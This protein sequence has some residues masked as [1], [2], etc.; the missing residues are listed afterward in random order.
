MPLQ[1][2]F[3]VSTLTYNIV[4][5]LKF[6]S[7]ELKVIGNKKPNQNKENSTSDVNTLGLGHNGVTNLM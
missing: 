7:M 3:Q 4:I 2:Q 1:L 5:L 6:H